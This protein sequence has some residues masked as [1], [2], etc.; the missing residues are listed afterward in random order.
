MILAFVGWL[1]TVRK[2]S[3]ST[4]SQYLSGLRIAHLK[5]GFFPPNLRPD[6]VK[7]VIK[8]R[9]HVELKNKVPRLTMTLEE[10]DNFKPEEPRTEAF[11]LGNLQFGIS[12]FIQNS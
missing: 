3:S 1:I 11:T 6:L 7:L 4:I 12:W 2:V 8:G 10:I 5:K 9:E